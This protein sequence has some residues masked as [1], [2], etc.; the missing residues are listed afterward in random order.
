ML[1][2]RAFKR[3]MVARYKFT[4]R[5]EGQTPSAATLVYRH[6]RGEAAAA[7]MSRLKERGFSPD[8]I[9]GHPGWGELMFAKDVFPATPMVAT[10]ALTLS[11]RRGR[12]I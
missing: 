2:T 12:T 4:P 11:S 9:L 6:Q 8:I 7:A 10:S 1:P 5:A 3:M